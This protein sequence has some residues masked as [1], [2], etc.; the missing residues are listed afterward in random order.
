[1]WDK[2]L[3]ACTW[4]KSKFPKFPPEGVSLPEDQDSLF[5]FLSF[6]TCIFWSC[7]HYVCV[8]FKHRWYGHSSFHC[9]L[10]ILTIK[11]YILFYSKLCMNR[12]DQLHGA[13]VNEICNTA[14]Q[15]RLLSGFYFS[16]PGPSLLQ[17][18][19]TRLLACFYLV[20]PA[21]GAHPTATNIYVYKGSSK[22]KSLVA[23][24][25]NSAH[26]SWV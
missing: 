1:M 6:I 18:T 13:G 20:T 23:F 15:D 25:L 17:E 16:A 3:C 7:L 11:A 22:Q 12:S 19:G 9:I 14:L 24:I 26:Q 2:D 4:S 5:L 10:Y 21:A 8:N